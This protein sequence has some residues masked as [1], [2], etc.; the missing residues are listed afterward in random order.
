MRHWPVLAPSGG[1]DPPSTR[2]K[3]LFWKGRRAALASGALGP[4]SVPLLEAAGV[5]PEFGGTP[6]RSAVFPGKRMENVTLDGFSVE[7][8]DDLFPRPCRAFL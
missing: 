6:A 4:A 1:A 5:V 8:P 3:K 2:W 7:W